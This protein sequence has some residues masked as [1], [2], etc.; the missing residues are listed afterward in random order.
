MASFT[1][2]DEFGNYI[3]GDLDSDE[4]EEMD[5][6]PTYTEPA[7]PLEGFDEEEESVPVDEGALMHIGRVSF[8]PD[9]L[10]RAVNAREIDDVPRN[11]VVLHEDKKYY[12]TA[13]EVYGEDVETMVQEEDAQPLSEPIVQP[14]KVR[15]WAIEE[16]G[17]PETRYDKGWVL[18]RPLCTHGSERKFPV[19][20]LPRGYDELSRN[21]TER[22]RAWTSPSR[23]NCLT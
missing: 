2:Y 3:G 17:L 19:R 20:Q 9:N 22:R 6:Q 15:K 18:L 10:T 23:E 7:Q 11:Q 8:L 14:I 16:K 1:D 12:P 4:D 5:A 21:D 13:Q